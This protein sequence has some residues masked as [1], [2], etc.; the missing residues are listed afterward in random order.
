[1]HLVWLLCMGL[2]VTVLV[3]APGNQVRAEVFAHWYEQPLLWRIGEHFGRRFP[4]AV[5]RYWGVILVM[6]VWRFA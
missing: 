3:L 5:L 1:W 4:D 2:G 6:L